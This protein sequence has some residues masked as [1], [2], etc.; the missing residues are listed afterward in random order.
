MVHALAPHAAAPV[1]EVFPLVADAPGRARR[2]FRRPRSLRRRRL[3]VHELSQRLEPIRRQPAERRSRDRVL[4]DPDVRPEEPRLEVRV[5]LVVELLRRRARD[6][7]PA[8]AERGDRVGSR[9]RRAQRLLVL[10]QRERVPDLVPPDHLHARCPVKKG[11]PERGCHRGGVAL[12]RVR[13]EALERRRRQR[14][15]DLREPLAQALPSP[16]RDDAQIPRALRAEH[17]DA[18]PR[19][20]V[21]V[22]QRVRGGERAVPAQVDLAAVSREPS[23]AER[24]RLAALVVPRLVLVVDGNARREH[25]R[26][27]RER[28]LAR[29]V[30]EVRRRRPVERSGG[31]VRS[32][33]RG[34]RR[35]RR[36]EDD[37]GRIAAELPRREDVHGDERHGH[38]GGR[39]ARARA[40]G[41]IFGGGGERKKE[42]AVSRPRRT[43]PRS[44]GDE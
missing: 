17:D 22:P 14:Q 27:L 37:R 39:R 28:E 25:E 2:L 32:R 19:H 35:G 6:H 21:R 18:R 38:R 23:D 42:V 31:I 10:E 33:L 3:L 24:L 34:L 29:D 1:R 41:G 8:A 20:E 13:A 9:R 43:R 36:Q 44:R 11:E 30:R 16:D 5:D 12:L 40:S 7:Q 4:V 26:R 15:R